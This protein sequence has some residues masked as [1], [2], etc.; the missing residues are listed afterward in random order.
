MIAEP[1]F[2]PNHFLYRSKVERKSKAREQKR[3][4]WTVSLAISRAPWDVVLCEKQ[5]TTIATNGPITFDLA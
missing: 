1:E 5:R 3:Q 2:V 4:G